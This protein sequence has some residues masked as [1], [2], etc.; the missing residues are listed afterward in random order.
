M[1]FTLTTCNWYCISTL[2]VVHV[3][4]SSVL[5]SNTSCPTWFYYNN[6]TCECGQL[7]DTKVYCNQQER[8]AGI[9]DGFC[10]TSTEQE[11]QYYAGYCPFRHTENN[12]GRI[13]SEMPCDP[14]LLSDMMC[15]HYNRKGLLCGRCIDGYGPAVY[16]F[17]MKCADCSKISTGSAIS[18]Y[19]FLELIPITLFFTCVVLF[20]LNITAG[21]L[22]GYVLFCQACYISAVGNSIFIY[23]YL[24]SHVSTTPWIMTLSGLWDLQFFKWV[25][26][27][28][29]ISSKLTG[30]HIQML[31]LVTDIYPVLLLILTGTLMELHAKNYRIIH[32][33]WKPF[34]ILVNKLNITSVTSD[35]VV[36]GFATFILLSACNL[37]YTMITIF[38]HT[39][40]YKSIDATL[41]KQVLYYEPTIT[42]FGHEHV[43]Y[44]VFA[45]VPF[46]LLV[47]IPSLL[48]CVYPTRIY[49]CLSQFVSARKRLAITAFAEALNSCFKDGLNGTR[50]Y[51]ALA[52]FITVAAIVLGL[53]EVIITKTTKVKSTVAATLMSIP[54]SL[55]FSY[56]RPC[57]LTIANLSLSYHSLVIGILTIAVRWWKH[58]PSIATQT[59]E[60]IFIIIPAT[61]HIL[62]LMWAGY[63]L[64][65]RIMSHFGYQLNPHD[66]KLAL[67][68][69][70]NAVKRQFSRQHGSYQVLP[71]TT[72]Q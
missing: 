27:P 10:A 49:G 28:F 32:I 60:K 8:E 25:I 58:D 69:L 34:S 68:D 7:F 44:I 22:L 56:V 67:T 45:A 13:F 6:V 61:S 18:L 36:H 65:R 29:C 63:A 40:V 15:G 59:L 62:V 31:N 70:A 66:C 1:L 43:I 35:A 19:L 38:S 55:F 5:A 53:V 64:T 11:G 48:L 16:S 4:L 23:E 30:I 39:P 57:K 71:D 72:T 54:L 12:R 50:D 37:T 52:G 2:V 17:N 3:Y 20:R 14:N 21:P 41:Y 9:T 42:A 47:L 24:L 46:I 33:L 51:R 26:P